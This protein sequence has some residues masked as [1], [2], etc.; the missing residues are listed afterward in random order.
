MVS[1][2]GCCGFSPS[3]LE[4]QAPARPIA[5]VVPR[6]PLPVKKT[7]AWDAVVFHADAKNHSIGM[8]WKITR[9]AETTVEISSVFREKQ[10]PQHPCCGNSGGMLWFLQYFAAAGD[11]VAFDISCDLPQH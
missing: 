4:P 3:D 10:K 2:R 9:N 5:R 1:T 11:A 8:L 7:T 6:H